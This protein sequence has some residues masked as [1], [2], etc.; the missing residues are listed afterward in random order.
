M[1]IA[2]MKITLL[3][4]SLVMVVLF[5]TSSTHARIDEKSLVGMW[6]FDV[7]DDVI[8]DKSGNCNDG[9]IVGQAKWVD[10]KFGGA[11]EFEG[12]GHVSVPDS[13]SLDM[14]GAVTVM[15][16]F[17]TEKKM[18]VFGDRQAVVGKHYLEYEVGIYPAGGIHTYTNDG[19]GGG[20]DEGINT[21]IAGKLPDGD[22]DW[23]LGKWYHMAWTLDETHETV[24]VN[25]VLIG[26]FDKPNEGTQAQA[27]TLEIGRRQ[28]GSLPFV[29]IVDEVA[30]F[31]VALDQ[32]DVQEAFERG[33]EEALGMA[34]VFP[35]D[36]LAAT[37]G[38]IRNSE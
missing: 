7:E 20:Y 6:L 16:W 25:G 12:A 13:D 18:A 30:I 35:A 5:F 28:A 27:H 32:E 14:T 19:T 31:N 1:R 15:F 4:M 33:L 11:L 36:K 2:T 3:W 29:G 21:A 26:E 38:Q 34:A 10:G 23:D 8:E 24:Y 22:A 17:A 9:A 37:W